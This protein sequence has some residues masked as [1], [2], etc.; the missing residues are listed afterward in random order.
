MAA[1]VRLQG[2]YVPG[3]PFVPPTNGTTSAALT[4]KALA[5]ASLFGVPTPRKPQDRASLLATVGASLAIT[6]FSLAF[7]LVFGAQATIAL[8]CGVIGVAL[9]AAAGIENA[10]A[11]FAALNMSVVELLWRHSD[12]V[13]T[14][15]DAFAIVAVS[16][17]NSAGLSDDDVKGVLE[18][19]LPASQRFALG[20]PSDSRPLDM[21]EM[22]KRVRAAQAQEHPPSALSTAAA[23]SA[24]RVKSCVAKKLVAV[25]ADAIFLGERRVLRRVL[26]VAGVVGVAAA[27]VVSLRRGTVFWMCPRAAAS[28]AA[29][30]R[31][32]WDAAKAALRAVHANP[33]LPFFNPLRSL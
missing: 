29:A 14:I 28:A 31:G 19:M 32:A 18:K 10:R 3:V 25:L 13:Q 16:H 15:D 5:F 33:L 23:L 21:E 12:A 1:S 7:I 27:G 26:A 4:A 20:R 2:A 30:T 6:G 8:T 24:G 9:L 22:V 17:Q 11:S